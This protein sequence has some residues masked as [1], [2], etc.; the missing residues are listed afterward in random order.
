MRIRFTALVLSAICLLPWR[1]AAQPAGKP[2]RIHGQP[3]VNLRSG[4]DLSH[5]AKEVLREGQ[6]VRVE[7]E[8]GN[9]YLVTLADGRHG[10]VHRTLVRFS[11]KPPEKENQQPEKTKRIEPAEATRESNV[12]KPSAVRPTREERRVEP[13]SA[14]MPDSAARIPKAQPLPVSKVLE[15]REWEMLGWFGVA[16]CIF[17][18]GW[19]CGG[20]YYLRRDRIKR[21]KIHF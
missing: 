1:V 7:K 19:I 3:F 11:D 10:Y 14:S 16:F 6:E 18:V 2:A 8:E 20:N 9:W 15:G 4:P 17:V 5:P 12:S 21:T 13:P